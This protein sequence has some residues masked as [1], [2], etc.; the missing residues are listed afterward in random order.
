MIL[1]LKKTEDAII[2]L[3]CKLENPYPI[4]LMDSIALGITAEEYF[5][6][7]NDGKR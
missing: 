4:L 6:D 2:A 7:I 5:Q 1:D 3:N